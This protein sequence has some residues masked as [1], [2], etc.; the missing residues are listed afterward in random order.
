MTLE[1]STRIIPITEYPELPTGVMFYDHVA[2]L[3][4]TPAAAIQ[5]YVTAFG[6]EPAV[7]YHLTRPNGRQAIYIPANGKEK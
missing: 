5:Q 2:F 3:N 7:V 6:H 1:Q 4:M